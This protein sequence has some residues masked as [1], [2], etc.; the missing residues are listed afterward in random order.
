MRLM[1]CTVR[2]AGVVLCALTIGVGPAHG[3]GAPAPKK[4]PVTTSS[5]EARKLYLQARDLA[6]KLRAVDANRLYAGGGNDPG[7]A[8]A[9]VGVANTSR[10]TKEFLE[11]TARGWRSPIESARGGESSW[12]SMQ[13]RRVSRRPSSRTTSSWCVSSRTT[14]ERTICSATPTS[15][16]RTTRRPSPRSRKPQPSVRRFRSRTTPARIR[17]S[18]PGPVRIRKRVQEVRRAD[19]ERSQS[20]R[21]VYAELL[22]KMGRFDESIKMSEKAL[23]IDPN[24]SAS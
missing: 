21:L 4:V 22:M 19:S 18:L 14:S 23:A 12:R 7:L 16:A 3:Q 6:E 11:A 24:F 5:E 17:V 8:L 15:A 9:H 10:P 2:M 20:I 1:T 13:G